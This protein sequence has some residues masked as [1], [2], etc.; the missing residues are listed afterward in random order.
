MAQGDGL[1]AALIGSAAQGVTAAHGPGCGRPVDGS[2]LEVLEPWARRASSS[3][4]Q[5]TARAPTAPPRVT[6]GTVS[7]LLSR[8]TLPPA[9][10]GR[11]TA[12]PLGQQVLE[13]RR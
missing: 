7:P 9:S 12:G 10:G 13:P 6:R 3:P 8:F 4:A 2:L 11:G 5:P 1:A